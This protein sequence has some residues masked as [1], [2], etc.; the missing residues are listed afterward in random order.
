MSRTHNTI[1]NSV[2]GLGQ[3]AL[4]LISPFIIRT[5][6]IKTLGAD[7]LGLNGLFVSILQVLNLVELGFSSAITFSLYKPIAE[8][9]IPVVCGLMNVYKKI[10]RY[11][12]FGILGLGLFFSPFLSFVIKGDVPSDINIYLLYY[13]YLFNTASSYL[14]FAYK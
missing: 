10:Y 1:R 13:L 6:I 3:K 9:N 8:K 4:M 2:W 12:G 7:Y 14:L 11:V 5:L